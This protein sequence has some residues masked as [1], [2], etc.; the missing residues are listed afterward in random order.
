MEIFQFTRIYLFITIFIY[1]LFHFQYALVY[2]I[3][4][5]NLQNIS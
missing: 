1:V 4:I 5:S 2:R 3:N